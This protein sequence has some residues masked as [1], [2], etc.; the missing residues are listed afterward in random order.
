MS[1]TTLA[2]SV[3]NTVIFIDSNLPDLNTLIASLPEG[4]EWVLLD[5]SSDGITQMAEYLQG[6]S[7]LDSVQLLSHGASGQISAGS[8]TL[9][10]DTI[11]NHSA[12]LET[13]GA[14]LKDSGDFLIYG[15]NVAQGAAGEALV[16]QI[17]SITQADVAA[18]DDLTGAAAKGG[19]W[20][21]EHSAGADSIQATAFSFGNYDE[22]LDIVSFNTDGDGEDEEM[23]SSVRFTFTGPNGSVSYNYGTNYNVFPDSAGNGDATKLTIAV[24]SGYTFDLTSFGYYTTLNDTITVTFTYANNTTVTGTLAATQNLDTILGNFSVFHDGSGRALAISSADDVIKVVISSANGAGTYDFGTNNFNISDVKAIVSADATS[25]VNAG[26]SGEATTFSTTATSAASATSLLDFTIT[27]PGTSDGAVTKVSELY[28]NVSGT[29]ISSELSK[30]SFLLNGPDATNMVGTYDSST[31]RITFSG[32]TLSVADGGN[33][34]YT[35]KAYYNDN[36]SSNDIIDH[37][38]VV[39]SVNASNFTSVNG[40]STF[41]SSQANVT[42]GSGA[43]IDVVATKL[44]YSQSPSTAAVSGVNFTTQPVVIAVDD[45]GNIDTDFNGTITL[46]ENGSGSLTGTTTVTATNGV[47]TFSGVKYTSASDAD[48]NFVLTAA[49]GSLASATSASINPDVVATRLVFSTQPVPTTIQSGQSSDFTTVPVVQAVDA[50]GMVDQDYTSNIVLSVTDPNDGTVDGTVNSLTVTSGDQDASATTV[51]L[52]PS[53]GIAT[54][55]GLITQYTNS[56][57][58]NT[59]ALR[60]TSGSLTAV[61]SSSITSTTD[62]APVFSNLNGGATYT[63]NGSAVVIDSNV[64][65][66]D[67]ELDSSNNYN[68]ASITIARNGG[69]SSQDVFGNSGLLGALVQGQAFTYNGTTVGTVTTNASG[70]LKL[71]FN[72]S[73]TSAMVDAVLQSLTYANDSNDPPASVTLNWTFNDGSLSSSGSNQAVLSI[74]PVNDAPAISN[75][76]VSKTFN[77][78]TAQTF[79][80]ADFGFSDVDSGDTLKSITVVTAPTAGELFIDANSNGVRDGA[81]T[82]IANNTVVTA[83][84]LAQLTYRP[85]A[86]ANG[87]GYAAFTWKVSDGTAS[88]ANVGTMTLNV[89]AVNDAPVRLG[90]VGAQ[91]VAQNAVFDF[92]VPAGTFTDPDTGDTLTLSAKLANGSALPSWLSFD[93]ATNRFSGTPGNGDVGNLLILVTAS[94]GSNALVSTNFELA[95]TSNSGPVSPSTLPSVTVAQNAVFGYTVPAGTFGNMQTLSATLANGSALPSWLIFNSATCSFSGTPG[96]RDVGNLSIQVAATDGRGASIWVTFGLSVTN[97]NDA[98]VVLVPVGAQT[99]AQ[100]GNFSLTIPAATFTDPDTGDTLTLSATQADGS[101]LPGWLSFNPSTRIFSGTPGNGDV[102][103]LSIR[104]TATDGS[105]ASVSTTFGLAVTS[106]SGG[107]DTPVTPPPVI[108][109]VDGTTI[110][111]TTS[112]NPQTGLTEQT[113]TVPTVTTGRVDDP[114]TVHSTMADIPVVDAGSSGQKIVVGLP[115]GV[116]LTATGPNTTLTA[117]QAQTTFTSGLGQMGGVLGGSAL[118]AGAQGYFAGLGG[119]TTFVGSTLTLTGTGGGAGFTITGSGL[120]TSGVPGGSLGALVLNTTQLG[121]GSGTI[122]LNDINFAAIVGSGTFTGGA[123]S[124]TVFAD[125]HSQNICLGADDDELHGGGGNDIIGSAGGNDI[126]DGGADND[127]VYGGIGNDTVIGGEGNDSLF[128]GKSDQGEWQFYLKDS[129]VIA[130]HNAELT[131]SGWESVTAGELNTSIARLG[132]TS[133]STDKLSTLAMLYDAAFGRLPDLTGLTYWANSTL[134]TDQIAQSFTASNEWQ[135]TMGDLNN[136]AFIEKLYQ[137]VLDRTGETTGVDYWISR[138]EGTGGNTTLSRTDVFKAFALS[139]EHQ[140]AL[141]TSNGI[142]LGTE[143]HTTEQN[144]ISNSGNDLLNGGTGSDTIYGG[145]GIDTIQYD[146]KLSNYKIL[147]DASGQIKVL[148]I[149]AGDIDTISGIEYGSFADGT[150]DLHFTQ[151][152]TAALQKVGLLYQIVLGR[153]GDIAGVTYW[154]GQNIDTLQLTASFVNSA[155]FSGTYGSLNNAAFVT[156]LYQNALHRAPDTAGQA[157]WESYLSSHSRTELVANWINA[158]EFV[159]GQFGTEGLWLA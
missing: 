130:L 108:A 42:N 53:G 112:T 19:D 16:Q 63:E 67:T 117:T 149:A 76:S 28:A 64:T 33:E 148:D 99:V 107:G 124:N 54:Y 115:I 105:N 123:G 74:T 156:A 46:T 158:P 65:V 129:K 151:D 85:A 22:L 92:T 140:S 147:L 55:A 8:S 56:G 114:N 101:A 154:A 72:A 100:N 20:V 17:A 77:E 152:G 9:N 43:S 23:V 18:S 135:Q 12:Q 24:A 73:A 29:A 102:G 82:A 122:V 4:S 98:P 139:A 157:Y 93:P 104:V 136:L 13:I 35:I 26:S 60:A 128:G 116:G 21:L 51:T 49:S 61:N 34:T 38:T 40:G 71:S 146:G 137:N 30:M 142:A 7:G 81:E 62:A 39:L 125:D 86:N 155:E 91:T 79:S 68:G 36:T 97:V 52:T 127:I 109:V 111:Q 94:D 113:I 103:N 44:I 57:S 131:Q 75:T 90:S 95:I 83:A 96:N 150:I 143:T 141:Q 48:A 14:A 11:A 58:T 25:T 47:A 1:T 119:G 45:R 89:T 3:P 133:A 145:D 80:A 78:D 159:A 50:N 88:S 126:V 153:A 121:S 2:A 31:G 41:A 106:N 59:L 69:A 132:F 32:L 84:N 6:R 70:A 144:W 120:G 27:D 37:H 15:C 10:A 134:S 87:A 138:L 66:A 5:S 110:Q 118:V